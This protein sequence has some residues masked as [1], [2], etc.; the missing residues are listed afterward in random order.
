MHIHRHMGTVVYSVLPN[1]S[2]VKITL[3]YPLSYT[4]VPSLIY[5]GQSFTIRFNTQTPA[6]PSLLVTFILCVPQMWSVLLGQMF[7]LTRPILFTL[8]GTVPVATCYFQTDDG[9]TYAQVTS[10]NV[11]V[12]APVITIT[13]P[14]VNSKR[15]SGTSLSVIWTSTGSPSGTSFIAALDCTGFPTVTSAPPVWALQ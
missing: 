6:S 1:P 15:T 9:A 2:S 4:T 3:K 5:R 13:S 10:S 7:W 8:P 12:Q 14:T 11:T